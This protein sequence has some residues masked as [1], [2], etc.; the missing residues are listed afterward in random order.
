MVLEDLFQGMEYEVLQGNVKGSINGLC[1]DSR[2]VAEDDLFFCIDGAKFKGEDF[3]DEVFSR[4]ACAIV[5]ERQIYAPVNVT[6]I[7]V[8]NV[9]YTMAMVACTFFGNPSSKLLM[10]GVTGTKGKT[11]TAFMIQRILQE[12]GY[13][14]GLVG[15]VAVVDANGEH[16]AKNTTPESHV[17]QRMLA[18]MYEQGIRAVVM[19]V[20]SQGLKQN[21]VT[22]ITFDYGV[23]TNLTPDHIGPFEHDDF[24]EYKYWKTQLFSH[25]R[26]GIINMDDMYGTDMCF[27]GNNRY[28]TYGIKTAGDYM[29]ECPE[30]VMEKRKY[31]MRYQL[32]CRNKMGTCI[33]ADSKLMVSMPGLFS[34]YNSLA[35][36]AVCDQLGI[37]R[38]KMCEALQKI[39]VPGRM[40]EIRVSFAFS[41]FIDY[42]H[43]ACALKNLLSTLRMYNPGRIIVVFGCGGNR[44]RDRRNQ[45]GR[46]AATLA[47]LSILTNDNPRF[48]KPEDII[49]DIEQG[50]RNTDAAFCKIYDRK[51]AIR[52]ALKVAGN[53]DIVILAGKGHERYQ[54][55][56]GVCYDMDERKLIDEIMEEEN[57][58]TICGYNHRYF[59]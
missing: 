2:Q 56:C 20:S 18:Q 9:R 15:T 3:L 48:E 49:S 47:D 45:M 17:L 1:S 10:I 25:S 58:T 14:T 43:N 21:R 8:S 22:G 40:E 11:T 4:G 19:E 31:G 7:L 27:A 38:N 46:V 59:A 16:P 36:I 29:A 50:F 28:V 44:S 5:S 54:E 39:S 42:A 52:Y 41:V 37:S 51:E 33:H 23:F 35:A 55:I 13:K 6:I 30:Y 24:E 53:R 34:V 12:A 32:L 26:V 57:V